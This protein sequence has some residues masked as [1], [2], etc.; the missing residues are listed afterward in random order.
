MNISKNLFNRKPNW[1]VKKK[2]VALNREMKQLLRE[3]NLHTVCESAS[4]PNI[5]ECFSQNTATL[6]VL[7]DIC[8]RNCRFCGVEKG[9]PKQIDIAE[10]DNIVN[11][12]EKLNLKYIVLTMVTRDDLPDGG[13]EHFSNVVK[14]IRQRFNTD[15]DVFIEILTSDFFSKQYLNDFKNYEKDLDGYIL[16]L[17]DSGINVFGHNIETVENVYPKVRT[18]AEY[19]RSLNFLQTVKKNH[20]NIIVKTGIMLGLGE[21]FDEVKNTMK[22]V[23]ATGCDILTIGQYLM[24]SLNHYKVEKYLTVEEFDEYKAVALEIGFKAVESG[25]FVRSSY[26]AKELYESLNKSEREIL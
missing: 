21:K 19:K 20:K 9:N 3:H 5:S 23:F 1:L 18:I 2:D 7:G 14:N 17:V 25:P 4:C 10:P 12:I 24:P 6:M 8:T 26:K 13:A 11:V 22:D 16:K 15:D